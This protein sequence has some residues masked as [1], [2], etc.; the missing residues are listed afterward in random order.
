MTDQHDNSTA[1]DSKTLDGQSQEQVKAL[2]FQGYQ[3]YDDGDFAKALRTFY[4]AWILLPKPQN[5]Y[6][7]AGWVLTAIGDCYFR[8]KQFKQ[9][10]EALRSAL[11]CPGTQNS[12]FVHLRNGQ[13]LFELGREDEAAQ[14][15]QLAVQLGGGDALAKEHVKYRMLL[16]H[17]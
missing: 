8:L 16:G 1:L 10:E 11:A 17:H 3:L 9:A 5:Q 12:P 2:C 7:E 4:Q 6:K 13:I 15:L 14:V